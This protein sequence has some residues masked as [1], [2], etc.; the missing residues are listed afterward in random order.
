MGCYLL[1][2]SAGFIAS[3]VADM[4]LDDGHVVFGLDNMND[5]YDVRMK[6]YRLANLE[7]HPNFHFQ[8]MDIGD[9]DRMAAFDAEGETFEAVINLA[10]RAGVRYS[11]ENP[12]EYF[13]TNLDGTLNL[14][15]FARRRKI[16]KFVL[17]SSSSVYG[18]DAPMPTPEDADT[19][20]PLQPYAASKKA[21]EVL[22]HA[23]HALYDLDVTIFRYFTVYGPAGRPDMV[24]FR[25][26]QWMCEGRTVFVNGD[27]KQSR[28]FTYVDDIAR[29]TILGLQPVGY[30]IFNLG[31]HQQVSLEELLRELEARIGSIAQVEYREAHPADLRRNWADV[32]KAKRILGWEPQFNFDE[33]LDAALAWY[34][35][36]R[37]WACEVDTSD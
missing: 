5:A 12:W 10:A 4:L 32:E 27:G 16:P 14:L 8:R 23:Y 28:G 17:A 9:R 37:T 26:I 31:G 11:V 18:L 1:T 20:R 36:E 6:E 3:R 33:G 35:S 30:E 7:K 22:C 25:F 19:D 34:Q 29:G 13:R 2:G 24:M 21:A 15:E